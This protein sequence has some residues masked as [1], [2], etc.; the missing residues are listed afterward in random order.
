MFVAMVAMIGVSV[1]VFISEAIPDRP[2]PPAVEFLTTDFETVEAC[3]GERIPFDTVIR[4]SH[5]VVLFVATSHLRGHGADGDTA[6]LARLGDIA[7]LIIP[8]ARTITD[9]DSAFTVPD[10]PP[11]DYTRVLAAGTLSEDSDPA[12]RLF[13]YTIPNDCND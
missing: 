6:K 13:P 3:P 11:G 10:L 9:E 12:I 8:T 1:A 2:Q 7:A 4:I 5:P